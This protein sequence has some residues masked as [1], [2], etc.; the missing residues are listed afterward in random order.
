MWDTRGQSHFTLKRKTTKEDCKD[1]NL[2]LYVDIER[3]YCTLL[4]YVIILK[5]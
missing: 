2:A 1:E 5:V 4:G 3:S